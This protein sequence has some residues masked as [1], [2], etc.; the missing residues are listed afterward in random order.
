MKNVKAKDIKRDWHFLD[1]RNQILGRL[2]VQTARLLMGKIKSY[3]TPHLDCGDYVVVVNA[4]YVFLSGK[5]ETQK[6]YFRHSGYPG[7]FSVQT[8]AQ[9]RAKKPEDLI[10]QAVVGM[11]PKTKLGK[12]MMKK[13]YIFPE[14]GHPYGDKFKNQ[15]A[16]HGRK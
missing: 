15:K 12:A 14:S 9:I 13:L 4:K 11:L 5:K 1:A 2:S 3:Y 7:G 6:K 8:A 16:E 10:R